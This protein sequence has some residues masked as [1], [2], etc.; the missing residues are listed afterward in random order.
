M[1]VVPQDK[2]VR[3]FDHLGRLLILA[4]A[5]GLLAGAET[6][7]SYRQ[8][9]GAAERFAGGFTKVLAR[10]TED[11]FKAIDLALIGIRDALQAA[12]GRAPNDPGFRAALDERLKTHPYLRAVFVIGADGFIMHETDDPETP[13]GSL[14]DRAYFRAHRDDPGLDLHIGKPLHSRSLGVW[15]V[16][17]SRR[18]TNPDGSF[19]GIV[20]AAVEPRYFKR[21]YEGL[22]LGESHVI[23]LALRDGTLLARIPKFEETIGT[24]HVD[25]PVR[26]LALEHGSGIAWATSSVDNIARLVGYRT[27]AGGSA[28]VIAGWST[29]SILDA[30]R[31][32]AAAVGLGCTLIWLLTAVLAVISHQ[33]RRRSQMEHARLAQSRRLELMGRIVGGIAHDLG[34]TVKIART[35]FTLLKPSLA[36]QHDA[37]ALVEDADRSLKSAFEIIDR[38]LAFARRQELSPRPT[39]L[40]DLL[41]GFSPIL[42]QAAGHIELV[43]D[44]TTSLVCSVDPIHLE[45]AL[46]NLVLN[47]KDAMANGGHIVIGL[48]EVQAPHR[49]RSRRGATAAA[50]L[51]WAEIAVKDDGVG[52]PRDV[53]DRALEPF[54][55]T[56]SNGSG[57][58][59]SQ[60]LGFV[61]QSS[62]DVRIDS[63][64][65]RG[66]IV[67]LLFPTTLEPVP[68]PSKPAECPV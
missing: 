20:V 14:E 40:A 33:H 38:L 49:R 22:S 4:L 7:R 36:A 23:S 24:K 65:G 17:F 31:G 57:L 55:T 30:W 54:F 10:Q 5:L 29:A 9:T 58:G 34:N 56:R 45:S 42:R 16:S 37:M 60:V 1:S 61:K 18:I 11:I 46:L 19:G 51:P 64:E 39:D 35:T 68:G 50:R 15:F 62:G 8:A 66:T 6:W 3:P 53:L 59:L 43:L 13:R 21:F 2:A 25:S 63:S 44:L 52:M 41:E 32:H 27:L 48:R 28:L 12:P 67:R 26:K 47:S